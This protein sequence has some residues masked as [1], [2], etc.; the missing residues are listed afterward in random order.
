MIRQWEKTIQLKLNKMIEKELKEWFEYYSQQLEIGNNDDLP[1]SSVL[2]II[3]F[4]KEDGFSE[5][6]IV[7]MINKQI[8][9]LKI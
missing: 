6:E 8:N 5:K 1:E 3:E 2:E 4:L 7:W 9:K